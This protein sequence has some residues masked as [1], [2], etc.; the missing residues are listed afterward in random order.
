MKRSH[1]KR[2]SSVDIGGHPVK[3]TKSG[4]R[5][6]RSEMDEPV[7]RENFILRRLLT[8]CGVRMPFRASKSNSVWYYR[9]RAI[10]Q[11]WV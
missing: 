8:L 3:A 11:S 4:L 10:E 5:M 6:W 1:R 9:R 7:A 2:P